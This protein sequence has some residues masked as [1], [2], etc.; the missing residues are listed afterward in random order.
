[1]FGKLKELLLVQ[2]HES[3]EVVN[4]SDERYEEHPAVYNWGHTEDESD[5]WGYLDFDN[6]DFFINDHI[7][8]EAG[9][10]AFEYLLYI[11]RDCNDH[12]NISKYKRAVET[13]DW[14]LWPQLINDIESWLQ[15]RQNT[16][17]REGYPNWEVPK[18]R[19][20]HIVTK[21]QA[22]QTLLSRAHVPVG[23]IGIASRIERKRQYWQDLQG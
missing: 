20:V 17:Q 11:A 21:A 1:M 22:R 18:V 4:E 16:T 15:I 8:Q 13:G 2:S 5:L 7:Y 6:A 19:I 9:L 23:C 10:A 12:V 14:D 3:V